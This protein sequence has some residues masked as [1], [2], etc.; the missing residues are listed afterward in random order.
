VTVDLEYF[1]GEKTYLDVVSCHESE[2]TG[3]LESPDSF[4]L[5]IERKL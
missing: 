1:C 2:L 3:N 5:S 4:I